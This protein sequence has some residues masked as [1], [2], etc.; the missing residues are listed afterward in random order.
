LF[1]SVIAAHEL[2]IENFQSFIFRH[3]IVEASTAVKGQ[4]FKELFRRFPNEDYFV[5]LDP[6]ILV[7]GP[8]TELLEVMVDNAVILIPHL[9]EPED[10]HDA[11]ADNEICALKHGVFNLGFLAL[12]RCGESERFLDWWTHRL[13]AFCYADLSEG[14]FTDQRWVDLAPCFFDVYIFRHPGYNVAPWNLSKRRVREEDEKFYVGNYPLRFFHFSGFDSGANALMIEKY[15]QNENGPIYNLRQL[16]VELID[17]FGQKEL[18]RIP[19]SYD[20]YSNGAKVKQHHRLL[21]RSNETLQRLYKQPYDVGTAPSYYDFIKC[22][23]LIGFGILCQLW[24]DIGCKVVAESEK[25][26]NEGGVKLVVKKIM[27]YVGRQ[28]YKSGLI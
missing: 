18:G 17:T 8:F 19:W 22:R 28:L 24:Q 4:L 16:Y 2:G 14:L 10:S 12:K 1:D 25:A 20:Y 13:Y 5:Y 3:S 6:D 7:T 9:S 26:Y 15:S 21:Y 23:D 11:I 27:N